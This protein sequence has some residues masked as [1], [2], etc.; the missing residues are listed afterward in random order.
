MRTRI[1]W[2]VLGAAAAFSSVYGW[3]KLRFHRAK[4]HIIGTSAT[5][6]LADIAGPL[7]ELKDARLVEGLLLEQ[8]DGL[9]G[10]GETDGCKRCV[11]EVND[12]RITM[13]GLIVGTN[14]SFY[15]A[16]FEGVGVKCQSVGLGNSDYPISRQLLDLDGDG[17]FEVLSET[18]FDGGKDRIFEVKGI[19]VKEKWGKNRFCGLYGPNGPFNANRHPPAPEKAENERSGKR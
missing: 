11:I 8:Y 5:K 14:L 6:E 3:E 15:S 2:F 17:W 12:G 10:I 9:V 13:I 1:L 4:K 19:Q 18:R 7:P 16:E